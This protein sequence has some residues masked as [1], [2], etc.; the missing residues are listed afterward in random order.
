MSP[1]RPALE[2]TTGTL[3]D[4]V[5]TAHDG[6]TVSLR[7]RT[8]EIVEL[9]L[10]TEELGLDGFA[11]GEHHSPEF[12][13]SSPAVVLAAV[14]ARTRR[15]GL[16][17]AVT[18]LAANDPVRLFEDFAT[19]DLLSTGRAELTVGRGAFIEP[20]ALFGV[21]V[22]SYDEVFA[23]R[24]DLLLRLREQRSITWS[25]RFRPPLHS[26]LIAPTPLQERLPVWIGVGGTPASA[27][28]AGALGL[29]LMIGSIASSFDTIAHLAEVYRAAGARAGHF[30]SL[31]LGI[32]LHSFT[33][34]NS[35]EAHAIYPYYR[36]FL[37]PKR[38]GVPGI[39]VTP[40][41]FEAGFSPDVARAIGT[42]EE[43]SDKLTR[44]HELVH[45]DRLQLLP[46]WGGM[47]RRT[48]RD[49]LERFASQV[50][51]RLRSQAA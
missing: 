39:H 21:P 20:F 24:L 48:A 3:T 30:D 17:T 33:A 2:I 49:S 34:A 29:P 4:F 36:D 25:G 40:A 43:V 45:Y 51:P 44:L 26:A 18:V 41:E 10:L 32:G 15:I 50:A 28:R 46:D 12:A 47:P 37:A 5:R 1:A 6:R 19:L 7:E 38:P 9:G 11:V 16:G 35:E 23:E 42:V 8:N 27:E 14:A 22:E 31:R 13:V